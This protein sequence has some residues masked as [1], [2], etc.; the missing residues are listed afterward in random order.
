MIFNHS[1]QLF[2]FNTYVTDHTDLSDRSVLTLK[3]QIQAKCNIPISKQ[4]LLVNG[5][6]L[7]DNELRVCNYNGIGT[8]S[9]PIYLFNLYALENPLPSN[10]LPQ[11]SQPALNSPQS[12]PN[13][14]FLST[15]PSS[16]QLGFPNNTVLSNAPS[17]QFILSM[18]GQQ[19]HDE[20]QIKLMKSKV[21]ESLNMDA[22]YSTI[23]TRTSIAKEIRDMT[24]QNLWFC[25]QLIRDQHLQYQ[26]W[27]AVIANL[28][29]IGLVFDAN[30]EKT[31][32][33]YQTFLSN[34]ENYRE[35]LNKLNIDVQLLDLIPVL[36]AFNDK[37]QSTDDE[38]DDYSRAEIENLDEPD[39]PIRSTG[40]GH[41][42]DLTLL[43]WIHS[44]DDRFTLSNL[45]NSCLIAIEHFTIENFGELSQRIHEVKSNLK[46]EDNKKIKKIEERL[47]QLDE[48][49]V[50]AKKIVNDTNGLTNAFI[51][52]QSSAGNVQD[53]SIFADLC[54]SHQAQLKIILQNLI[55]LNG[56]KNRYLKA[57]HE[58]IYNLHAKLKNIIMLESDL[59]SSNQALIICAE[60]LRKL[61]KNLQV[62]NQIH[63]TPKVYFLSIN[64]ILRRNLF[65]KRFGNWSQSLNLKCHEI[66]E[67][68]TDLRAQ[69]QEQVS[70]HFLTMLFSGLNDEFPQFFLKQMPKFDEQ[71][72]EISADDL[73]RLKEVLPKLK[74]FVEQLENRDYIDYMDELKI[75][76]D[77]LNE[78]LVF[79]MLC[80]NCFKARQMAEDDESSRQTNQSEST[81]FEKIF[82]ELDLINPNEKQPNG[83]EK[84]VDE[85]AEA[86]KSED[87]CGL[88]LKKQE[89]AELAAEAVENLNENLNESVDDMLK[90]E[91]GDS[92]K[93]VNNIELL[94]QKIELK[95]GER[96]TELR[97]QF[98]DEVDALKKEFAEQLK[99][100]LAKLENR[101]KTEHKLEIDSIRSRFKLAVALDRSQMESSVKYSHPPT[102]TTKEE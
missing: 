27:S 82:H 45:M 13:Q 57:K 29:D 34:K 37:S 31:I 85:R 16:N 9:T 43:E 61:L 11:A 44:K 97:K 49:L 46:N 84:P 92:A 5:G 90:K 59:S 66:Y 20:Q 99:Q 18:H 38:D 70:S 26:G 42:N 54:T 6:L 56:I 93:K 87:E 21:A 30:V 7:L 77:V 91:I 79:E 98:D 86:E 95:I 83:S 64:E 80:F 41:K 55:E 67:K 48:L 78:N 81:D 25:E 76:E 53:N 12:S 3:K 72:V 73:N 28:E 50:K 4:I 68:E 39:A 8:D 33:I 40:G 88:R 71:L 58:L 100:D 75:N 2:D 24:T 36:D 69:F 19:L 60:N 52:N 89:S 101:L 47:Y 17:S 96:E 22:S 62:L 15:S 23:V 74:E 14:Q 32:Q 102:K 51:Q 94:K 35:L 1:G 10:S 65:T 63:L